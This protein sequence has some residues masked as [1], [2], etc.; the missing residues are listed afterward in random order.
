MP[1]TAFFLGRQPIMDRKRE[2]VAYELLFRASKTNQA[3]ILDDLEASAAVIQ[4]A[5]FDLGMEGALGNKQGFINLS[6]G[7]LMSEMVE[8]LPKERVVLELLE[9]IEVTPE[10]VTR[11]EHLKRA[12]FRLALDDIKAADQGTTAL[13]PYADIVKI[14]VQGMADGEIRALAGKLQGFG[15]ELLAE[16]IENSA[17]CEVCYDA[18]FNYFQGYFFARPEILEGRTM[19]P[20]SLVLL[21]I[22]ALAN[23]DAEIEELEL[24][25]KHAP[26]VTVRLLRTANSVAVSAKRKI[27]SV[28]QAVQVLGRV[29]LGRLVQILM[30][31]QAGDG[32]VTSSPLAQIAITRG[33]L[34]ENLAQ[35]LGLSDEQPRAFMTGMLSLI[36]VLFAQPL[37][38]IIEFLN[39]D[40]TVRLALLDRAG[41]LGGMLRLVEANERCDSQAVSALMGRLGLHNLDVF[42]RLSVDALRWAGEF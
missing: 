33:R 9:S 13:I 24:A 37:G 22:F 8:A 39:L 5:F 12:G 28:R 16:K 38:N 15:G 6:S 25:L 20:S 11:C 26:D 34:M 2:L 29:Q 27:L 7:M 40:D 42:N 23:A 36:D 31:A 30:F 19:R 35:L 10:L 17:Q 18:G 1:T 21:K 41:Q 4:H 32:G 14:D 3:T